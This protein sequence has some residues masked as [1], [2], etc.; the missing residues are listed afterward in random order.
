MEY[1]LE[2]IDLN[3]HVIKIGSTLALA[4]GIGASI[5]FGWGFDSN[6]S[7]VI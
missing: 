2:E 7:R 4:G 1:T 6:P 3:A 5:F